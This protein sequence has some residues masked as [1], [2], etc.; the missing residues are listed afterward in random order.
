[1]L[2]EAKLPAIL[3]GEALSA[4][5]HIWNRSPTR[6]LKNKTPFEAWYN[7]KPSVSHLRVWGC[8]AY[9][10]VQKDL[11][12]NL[13]SHTQKCIFVGYPTGIKGWKFYDPETRKLILSNDAK[14]DKLN[15][16][17]MRITPLDMA[18]PPSI[19]IPIENDLDSPISP[20]TPPLRHSMR[21]CRPPA[22]SWEVDHSKIH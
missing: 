9:I 13:G 12:N 2:S 21:I 14:F 3:W 4:F 5:V 18:K 7:R 8:T 20:P 10:H 6:V 15:F 16:M 19:E 17:G 11:R 22:T 1:M